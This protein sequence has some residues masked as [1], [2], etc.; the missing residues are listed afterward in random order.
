MLP[1]V[2][3]TMIVRSSCPKN[4]NFFSVWGVTAG[5]DS[6]Y[7]KCPTE[8]RLESLLSIRNLCHSGLLA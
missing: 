4:D 5:R 8:A 1:F 3:L 7:L 6:H 2:H